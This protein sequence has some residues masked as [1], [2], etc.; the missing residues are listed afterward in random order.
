[1]GP[2]APRNLWFINTGLEH[3]DILAAPSFSDNNHFGSDIGYLLALEP[4]GTF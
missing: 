2:E 1:M 3:F 4:C